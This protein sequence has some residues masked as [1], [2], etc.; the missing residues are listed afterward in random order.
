MLVRIF[1]LVFLAR[2]HE[3]CYS[4]FWT[5]VNCL[6]TLK[7][8]TDS[9]YERERDFVLFWPFSLSTHTRWPDTVLFWH[10][11]CSSDC[12]PHGVPP[13][14][15]A[16]PAIVNQGRRRSCSG[17]AVFQGRRKKYLGGFYRICGIVKGDWCD[18]ITIHCAS[19]SVR[20]SFAIGIT[21][22]DP[23]S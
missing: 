14:P 1:I 16:H 8:R 12:S 13:Y 10:L 17:V 19:I 2:D 18:F 5:K 4:F 9:Q 6:F 11:Q 15:P 22:K 23:L 20:V 3:V 21:T 7:S